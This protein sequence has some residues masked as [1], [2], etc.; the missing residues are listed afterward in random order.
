MR[1]SRGEMVDAPDL[2]SGT[3]KC[4]GSTPAASTKRCCVCKKQRPLS[5]FQKRWQMPHLV[6]STC[7]K[8]RNLQ[9]A[10]LVKAKRASGQYRAYCLLH[11]ARKGDRKRGRANDLDRAFVD[12]ALK[13]PCAYCGDS[14]LQIT[15]DRKDNALGHLKANVVPAC[16]RC[17]LVRR[18]MPYDAWLVV[19]E[20]MRK[21][22]LT[23]LLGA[24]GSTP[25]AHRRA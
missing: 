3:A 19:A 16:I 8:C 6:R 25:L 22:R 1:C 18:D 9:N 24:W 11:D 10:A 23:G 20:G 21:A 12:A 13:E 7:R 15:L 5:A 4:A 17:N 14:S 2:G